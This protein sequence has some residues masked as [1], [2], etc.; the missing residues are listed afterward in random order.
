MTSRP[1]ASAAASKQAAEPAPPPPSSYLEGLLDSI[2]GAVVVTDGDGL[3][4][5]A[6]GQLERLGGR[7]YSDLLGTRLSDN[8]APPGREPFEELILAAAGAGDGEM[9]GPLRLA[10]IGVD[11][12]E[13]ATE[14]WAVNRAGDDAAMS[15]VV[16]LLLP[17]SAYGRFDRM[18]TSLFTREAPVAQAYAALAVAL[19]SPPVGAEAYFLVPGDDDRGTVRSPEL[20]EVP[21]PPLP[22]PWD[23]V[24]AGAADT[25]SGDL[26]ALPEPLAQAARAAGF[27]SVSCFTVRPSPEGLPPGCLVVWHRSDSKLSPAARLAVQ[28]AVGLATVAQAHRSAQEG[29]R[30]PGLRDSLTGLGNDQSLS[31]SLEAH[32]QDGEQPAMLLF[33]LDGFRQ[34]SDDL[35]RLAGEAVLRVTARR[36]AA[37]MRPTDDLVHLAGAE[38]A[39]V[40]NGSP[41]KDQ[42]VMIAERLV[43]QLSR[44]L[45]IGDGVS[46][47][48]GVS[49]GIA[50]GY[51]AGTPVEDLRRHADE[52]LEAA[53]GKGRSKWVV[54]TPEG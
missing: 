53:R 42:M 52:A 12:G 1:R 36:L 17:E 29:L 5:Y 7:G 15:G 9:A 16:L 25:E 14:V 32:V 21:G 28:R 27:G 2:P 31:E 8:V 46:A 20:A 54:A 35:G 51:P 18:L 37:V 43:E 34:V 22:G 38:F 40:C 6:A 24:L 26:S 23:D 10:Y 41:S 39:V 49:I 13:I 11:G 44:P 3:V 30:H 45:S 19:R 48:V 47:D 50:L 4:R 33:D